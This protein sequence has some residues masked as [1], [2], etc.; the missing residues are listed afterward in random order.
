MSSTKRTAVDADSQASF[1]P[2]NASTSVGSPRTGL[3]CMRSHRFMRS[4]LAR[5]APA[6]QGKNSRIPEVAIGPLRAPDPESDA[7][8][9]P[10]RY[11][12]FPARRSQFDSDH[13]A[14]GG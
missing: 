10:L 14:R 7:D 8:D 6:A 4:T 5:L 2:S 3:T 13:S 9:R 11:A 12:R 1:Q